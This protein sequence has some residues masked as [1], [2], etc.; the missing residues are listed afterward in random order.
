M[1]ALSLMATLREGR[2]SSE[3]LKAMAARL[4]KE[5]FEAVMD[6]IQGIACARRAQGESATPD[7]G[8][9][10]LAIHERTHPLGHLR[11]IVRKLALNFGETPT[12]ELMKNFQEAAGHRVDADLDA[13]CTALLR[14]NTLRRMPTTGQFLQ[15]CGICRERRK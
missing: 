1:A 10:L 5:P 3:Y 11:T 9:V 13:A 2:A 15:A 14:D 7:L 8:T 6:A 4:S 12:E